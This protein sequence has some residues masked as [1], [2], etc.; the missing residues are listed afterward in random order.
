MENAILD[1]V[2]VVSNPLR[3]ESRYRLYREFEARLIKNPYVRLT[4]VEMAFGHRPFEITVPDNPRHVQVR[5]TSEL[6]HKECLVNIGVQ[7]VPADGK[8]IAW[9]D[10][11]VTFGRDDWAEETVHQLQHYDVVQ[12]WSHAQDCGPKSQPVGKT[13]KGFVWS[14][15]NEPSDMPRGVSYYHEGISASWHPGFAWA[16]RRSAIDALGQLIDWGALGS[17]DRHMASALIGQVLATCNA[18]LSANYKRYLVRWQDRAQRY[19]RRNIGYVDGMLLHHW[20]GKKQ[21]RQYGDRW[22]ILVD[23][24]YDPELD[25]K[26]D[27]QGLWQLTDRNYKLRDKFRS[28]FYARNE[29]SIDLY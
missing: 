10:A 20:H 16:A 19:I 13:H 28:Y 25:L 18:N 4:T 1:V 27:S 12:M 23:E 8:Y 6:W 29:D 3:F 2:A 15:Y 5:G 17:G 11:D 22:K 7:N 21:D 9:I 24:Q 14:Y 26:R